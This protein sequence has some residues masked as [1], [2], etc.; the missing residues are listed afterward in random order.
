M[1]HFNLYGETVVE[2]AVKSPAQRTSLNIEVE[3]RR[4]YA[5]EGTSG[6]LKNISLTGAFLKHRGESL[7]IGEKVLVNFTVAGRERGVHAQ[8]I[9][10]NSYGS[11]VKFMP[12]NN[13]DTQIV[14]DLIYF[15]E[16]KREGTRDILDQIFK[17]VA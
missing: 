9:W 7:K 8:V 3:F 6:I 15:V 2:A 11:G 1:K 13:R 14:D 16:S 10:T 4:N 17:K 12:N 5:R